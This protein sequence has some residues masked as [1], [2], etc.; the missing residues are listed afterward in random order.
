MSWP[1]Q[2]SETGMAAHCLNLDRASLARDATIVIPAP[3]VASAG[4]S[5]SAA[6]ASPGEWACRA[7][8]LCKRGLDPRRCVNQPD[9]P[10]DRETADL[11]HLPARMAVQNV[12]LSIAGDCPD[13]LG[14][15]RCPHGLSQPGD[16]SSHSR[17]ALQ[18]PLR[19]LALRPPRP[20]LAPGQPRA[21]PCSPACME[22]SLLPVDLGPTSSAR[23]SAGC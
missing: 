18:M 5:L 16:G 13:I 17:I 1:G 14:S 2:V 15:A 9:V 10:I 12:L 22:L 11:A 7:L 6:N 23:S 20:I 4:S 8:V 21:R 3:G 19:S